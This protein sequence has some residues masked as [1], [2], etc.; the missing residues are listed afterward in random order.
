M[1]HTLFVFVLR[2]ALPAI[3]QIWEHV[4]EIW[5][6]ICPKEEHHQ[7]HKF[8]FWQRTV[9]PWNNLWWGGPQE[10]SNPAFCSKAAQLWGQAKFLRSS[11]SQDWG[12]RLQKLRGQPGPGLDCSY[13]KK[14]FSLYLFYISHF[15]LCCCLLSTQ[16]TLLMALIYLLTDSASTRSSHTFPF[17]RLTKSSFLSFTSW[18]TCFSL[19]TIILLN[20]FW[21]E[22]CREISSEYV[23]IV[24]SF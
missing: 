19:P 7:Q 10:L 13:N 15:S 20:Y 5:W 9:D 23:L 24:V 8:W 2:L 1:S 18:V 14:I 16:Q 3:F 22:H 4:L 17:F 12:W 6:A 11:F 21:N